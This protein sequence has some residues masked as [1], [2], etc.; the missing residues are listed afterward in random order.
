[1][2]VPFL[3][4]FGVLALAM[5]VLIVANV[6]TGSVASAVRRIGILK[7]LGFTP[8]EVVRAYVGQALLPA[9]VGA[10]AGVIAG[11]LLAVPLLGRIQV[12]YGTP[13][14]AVSWWVDLVVVVF[15][16]GVAA[17]TGA[18]GRPGSS[19]G[20]RC[21]ARSASAWPA[22]SP[23]RPARCCCWRRSRSGPPR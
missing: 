19:D 3:V 23:G 5:S 11:N 1:V 4:A 18:G 15:V 13:K 8:G 22:R 12:V 14:L 9:A 6:V 7:A 17:V 10:G 2:F 20:C 21:P 16:L